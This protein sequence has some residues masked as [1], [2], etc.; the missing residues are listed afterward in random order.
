M[1]TVDMADCIQQYKEL[2]MSYQR[3]IAQ[4]PIQS[5]AVADALGAVVTWQRQ[6]KAGQTSFATYV[7]TMDKASAAVN[8]AYWLL[9]G[10]KEMV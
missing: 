3:T 1:V 9:R 6:H 7:A 10:M 4:R 8:E 2:L 5:T